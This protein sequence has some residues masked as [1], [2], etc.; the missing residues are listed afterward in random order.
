M[1]KKL[2]YRR[3]FV[4]ALYFCAVIPPLLFFVQV[5]VL[6]PRLSATA[7]YWSIQNYPPGSE[8]FFLCLL[9]LSALQ[10]SLELKLS[11]KLL[12]EAE[13]PQ[14]FVILSLCV[15][16]FSFCLGLWVITNFVTTLTSLPGTGILQS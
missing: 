10:V 5:F 4:Y 3:L 13:L 14:S 16:I 9:I 8:L 7:D 1:A 15:L 6:G 12:T 11:R 2:I